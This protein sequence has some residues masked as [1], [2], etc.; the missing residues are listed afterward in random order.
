MNRSKA[1][2]ANLTRYE[3][4][5]AAPPALLLYLQVPRYLSFT[6]AQYFKLVSSERQLLHYYTTILLEQSKPP[7]VYTIT[8]QASRSR[9]RSIQ[10]KKREQTVIPPNPQERDQPSGSIPATFI[11]QHTS[12]QYNSSTVSKSIYLTFVPPRRYRYLTYPPS[13]SHGS[14]STY[15]TL[16]LQRPDLLN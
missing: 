13:L 12:Q 8:I 16:F 1:T 5:S 3:T 6:V 2:V 15:D 14:L 10:F 7:I 4:L 11:S 9:R